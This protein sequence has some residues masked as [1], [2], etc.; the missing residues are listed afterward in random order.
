MSSPADAPARAG[1]S[2]LLAECRVIDLPKRSDQRGHLSFIESGRHIP[3]AFERIFYLYGMPKGTARGGH[4]HR[5]LHQFVLALAGSFDMILHDGEATRRITLDRP[6]V[7]LYVAPMIWADLDG[8]TEGA[9]AAV[10]ASAPYEEADYIRDYDEYLRS[11][12]S[13]V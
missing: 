13:R 9:V 12:R 1:T 6:D 11:S 5:T 4:A 10:L 8:F 2:G 7:G 3:F